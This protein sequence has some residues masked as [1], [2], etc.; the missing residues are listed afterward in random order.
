[1]VKRKGQRSYKVVTESGQLFVE[2]GRISARVGSRYHDSYLDL[3]EGQL[4]KEMPFCAGE[5]QG[6]I[7]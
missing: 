6:S 4:P 5:R 3:D 1:M 7:S 2:I